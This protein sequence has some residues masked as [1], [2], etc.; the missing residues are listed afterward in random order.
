MLEQL[1]EKQVMRITWFF[2]NC[3]LPIFVLFMETG[4]I[5]A[6]SGQSKSD[7][8]IFISPDQQ[9][10]REPVVRY[11]GEKASLIQ[12][13]NINNDEFLD[14]ETWK[15]K[16]KIKE[17]E[18]LWR[19][20][21]RQRGLQEKFGYIL[22]CV[23]TCRSYRGIG[24]AR[25]QYLSTIREGDELQTME[26]SYAW[27]YL[28]DGTLLRM[29]PESSISFKEINIGKTKNFVFLRADYGNV[30]VYSDPKGAFKLQEL[31][32]TDSLF[33][34]LSHLEANPSQEE[35]TFSEDSL[36]KILDDRTV[37]LAKIKRLNGLIEANKT[38]KKKET[39]FFVV[40][41]N[42]TVHGMG[43]IAEFIVLQGKESYVKLRSLEQLRLKEEVDLGTAN[44]YFRGYQNTEEATLG[45][46]EW[47]VVDKDGRSLTT[48]DDSK[49]FNVGEFI[50]QNI[51]SILI[52]RELMFKKYSL[53][54]HEDISAK[55][56]AS[57]HGFL[58]WESGKDGRKDLDLRVGFLKE[59]TRRSETT[60]LQ[61]TEQF[62][63]KLADRGDEWKYDEYSRKYF[64][65]AMGDFYNY[66]ENA[67]ISSGKEE[68]LNSERKPFWKLI[69]GITE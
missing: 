51:P 62:R 60:S 61:V 15:I 28:L 42:G 12:W 54:F 55:K 13:D 14:F 68:Y 46:G 64:R 39:E 66:N 40:M 49:K 6:Q 58:L 34:P 59:F 27:I 1:V 32:E 4:F 63:Q 57:E 25:S 53:F 36:D 21:L 2:F 3:I 37:G 31:K 45:R 48:Y 17:D 41:P 33:L 26:D 9:I 56:L 44:F 69:N 22:D 7:P 19:N 20:N 23:G 43:L 30:L 29:G 18:P 38:M 52:A 10:K 5:H 47:Y 16:L 11:N 8:K 67:T 35:L 24:W 50:T 65:R